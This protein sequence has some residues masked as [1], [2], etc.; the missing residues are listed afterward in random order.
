VIHPRMRPGGEEEH[1]LGLTRA[2]ARADAH[3]FALASSV[4][5]RSVNDEEEPALLGNR[6]DQL[7]DGICQAI[8]KDSAMQVM[9]WE[10]WKPFANG[11]HGLS[12]VGQGLRWSSEAPGRFEE[13]CARAPRLRREFTLWFVALDPRADCTLSWRRSPGLR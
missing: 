11:W 8:R 13:P 2:G 7:V 1:D 4:M 9:G 5:W 3:A 10:V 6:Q 12:K